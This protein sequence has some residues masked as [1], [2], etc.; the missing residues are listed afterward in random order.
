ME[1]REIKYPVFLIAKYVFYRKKWGMHGNENEKKIGWIFMD[2][3]HA[4]ILESG[5]YLIRKK[6]VLMLKEL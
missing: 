2:D 5:R 6:S 4:L 1:Q 3:L